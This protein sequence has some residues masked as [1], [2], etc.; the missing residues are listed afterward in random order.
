VH[1]GRRERSGGADNIV[2]CACVPYI[3]PLTLPVVRD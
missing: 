1:E 3:Q 2:A